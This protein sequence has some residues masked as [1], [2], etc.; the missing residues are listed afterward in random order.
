[1]NVPVAGKLGPKPQVVVKLYVVAS[2]KVADCLA[3]SEQMIFDPS[4]VQFF[5]DVSVQIFPLT[6]LTFPTRSFH[7]VAVRAS[8]GFTGD[9]FTHAEYPIAYPIAIATQVARASREYVF[10]NRET[11]SMFY[12]L[13]THRVRLSH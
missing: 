9:M 6:E 5:P 2:T 10:V 8:P 4:L 1:M 3:G 12:V 11:I 7:Q 13:L